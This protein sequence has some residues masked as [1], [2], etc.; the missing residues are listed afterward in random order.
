MARESTVSQRHHERR[1]AFR[2][3][4]NARR[5]R[6]EAI[7]LNGLAWTPL[8]RLSVPRPVDRVGWIAERCRGR[9][10]LDLGAYDETALAKVA[11]PHWL[12]GRIA[13]VAASVLGVD[14]APD[15]PPQ[16]RVTGP[17]SRIVRGDATALDAPLLA[18][19]RF[20]VVVASELIE[21]LPDTLAFLAQLRRLLPG[22]EL[23]AS[24]PN[25]TSLTNVLLALAG[26][27]S[28][29]RDHLQVYSWKTLS[30]LCREAGIENWN[31]VPCAVRYTEMALAARG[32]RRA[33]VLAAER[34]VN[35]A[36]WLFPLLS[37]GLILHVPR[38]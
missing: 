37:G 6:T 34:A 1:G 16:G 3:A 32:A 8:E 10:V 9:R 15:L 24:T 4:R 19:D 7:P 20:D 28:A 35:T 38:L 25:A 22:C 17:R 13:A 30:A 12:H 26:R 14:S 36:A 18:D 21:H 5:V 23:I 2:N 11:T 27:E 33:A 31:V 29:H